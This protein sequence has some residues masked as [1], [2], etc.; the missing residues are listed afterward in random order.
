VAHDIQ[1]SIPT[2]PSITTTTQRNFE[3]RIANSSIGDGRT[4]RSATDQ[5]VPTGQALCLPAPQRQFHRWS[6]WLDRYH[7]RHPTE[8]ERADRLTAGRRTAVLSFRV[9]P[10]V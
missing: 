3:T 8:T 9:S 10:S 4:V 1:D 5:P 7:D 6:G 2:A